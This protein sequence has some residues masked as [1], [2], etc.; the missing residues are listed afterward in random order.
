SVMARFAQGSV[1][2]KLKGSLMPFAFIAPM[3]FLEKAL[4]WQAKP[5]LT[6][7]AVAFLD[8]AVKGA[9]QMLGQMTE[10]GLVFRGSQK[11]FD[12]L[13]KSFFEA[14]GCEHPFAAML[15][16]CFPAQAYKRFKK[17]IEEQENGVAF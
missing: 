10:A 4:S 16:A 8:G 7:E 1:D 2:E 13:A 14:K 12:A 9:A 11:T 15:A 6:A 3:R 5:N 17:A